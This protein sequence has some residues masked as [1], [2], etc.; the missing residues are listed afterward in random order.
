[1]L[2][3]VFAGAA[4]QMRPLRVCALILLSSLSLA[5]TAGPALAVEGS[6]EGG[7]SFSELSRK[8]S[9]QEQTTSTATTTTT[10]TGA[11]EVKNSDKTL[12][13]GFGAAVVLILAIAYV[14]M[15]DARRHTP[16]DDSDPAELEARANRDLA[17]RQAK[18]R[19]KA[20][21][22]RQQRKRNR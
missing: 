13:I 3:R 22:A 21:A 18:R 19:A 15:R 7:N 20:R 8:A 11:K 12:L 9:E 10:E 2:A 5:G 16:A 17:Q 1:M 14:I 4:R 6:V